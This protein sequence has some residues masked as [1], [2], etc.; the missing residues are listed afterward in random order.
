MITREMKIKDV[1]KKNPE[2]LKVFKKYHISSSNCGWG[3]YSIKTIE[4]AALLRHLDIE[5]ILNELDYI[6]RG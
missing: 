6:I 1:I 4:Q 5:D 3:G 2:T